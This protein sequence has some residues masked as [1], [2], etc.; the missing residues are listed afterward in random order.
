MCWDG[1][2]HN[3]VN[4]SVVWNDNHRSPITGDANLM[5]DNTIGLNLKC[6]DNNPRPH[7]SDFAPILNTVGGRVRGSAGLLRPRSSDVR[8][9]RGG[10]RP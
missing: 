7:L 4:G 10:G 5:D 8:S 3:V 1:F 2:N 9:H 6:F